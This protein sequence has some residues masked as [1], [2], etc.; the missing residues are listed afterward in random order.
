LPWNHYDIKPDFTITLSNKKKIYWEHLGKLGN[1]SYEKDWEERLTLYKKEKLLEN[2]VTT[3]ERRGIDDKKIEQ[4][5]LDIAC[6]G[7]KSDVTDNL[8]LKHHYYLS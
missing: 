3:D 6:D 5:I 7:L 2:L 8:Y 1:R 4:I